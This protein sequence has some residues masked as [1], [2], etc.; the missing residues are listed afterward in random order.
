MCIRIV[1]QQ[2]VDNREDAFTDPLYYILPF[3]DN[4][5]DA[6]TDPLYYIL[7]FSDNHGDAFTGPLLYSTILRQP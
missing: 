3:S 2:K 4:H 1:I 5:G 7:P 6:F